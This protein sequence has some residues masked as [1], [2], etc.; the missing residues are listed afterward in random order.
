MA[1]CGVCSGACYLPSGRYEPCY[2]CGGSGHGARTDQA[3]MACGG[4]GR[5][6]NEIMDPCWECHGAGTVADPPA[7][8][9][10]SGKTVNRRSQRSESKAVRSQKT[11]KQSSGKNPTKG[12]AVGEEATEKETDISEIIAGISVFIAVI[13]ALVIYDD[14]KDVGAAIGAGIVTFLMSGAAMYIAYYVLKIAIKILEVFVVVVFWGAIAVFAGNLLGLEWA[15][16]VLK[17]VKS[18]LA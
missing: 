1:V 6:S 3:C 9:D 11:A 10:S 17:L 14:K 7:Y 16:D 5:S 4:T 15:E 12:K 18:L 13:M 8:G 2:S